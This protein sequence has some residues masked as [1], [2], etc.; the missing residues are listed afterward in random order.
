[1]HSALFR[2][3]LVIVFKFLQIKKGRIISGGGGGGGG[4]VKTILQRVWIIW[5]SLL[6]LNVKSFMD[7]ICS[8]FI[9]FKCILLDSGVS[10]S[11]FCNLYK[12]KRGNLIYGRNQFCRKSKCSGRPFC[13]WILKVLWTQFLCYSLDFTAF[14]L[15][16]AYLC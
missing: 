11:D 13:I 5:C 7:P 15:I 8:S 6:Y 12:L 3:T 9:R 2:S 16:Q 14:S 4:G 10:F 1:M